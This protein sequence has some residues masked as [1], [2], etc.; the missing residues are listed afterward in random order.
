[1]VKTRITVNANGLILY[2]E[3]SIPWRSNIDCIL[4]KLLHLRFPDDA[5]L[6]VDLSYY[7]IKKDNPELNT[8]NPF[9]RRSLWRSKRG[10]K[11]KKL[12][13]EEDFGT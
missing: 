11:F 4:Y 5:C 7:G 10:V 6:G 12:S 13:S 2:R 8:S 1:M 9:K 3:S